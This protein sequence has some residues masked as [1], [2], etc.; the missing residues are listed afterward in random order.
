[1]VRELGRIYLQ[2]SIDCSETATLLTSLTTRN[3]ILKNIGN[4]EKYS[5]E[6]SFR[7]QEKIML[8]QSWLWV[9]LKCQK[10]NIYQS[11]EHI[12]RKDGCRW[13]KWEGINAQWLP[14]STWHKGI[15]EIFVLSNFLT[16]KFI[17]KDGK[18]EPDVVMKMF[19]DIIRTK[20]LS[21]FSSTVGVLGPACSNTVEAIAGVSKHYRYPNI[22]N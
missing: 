16:N 6:E 1:M 21:R 15:Y 10:N 3:A 2:V 18:C 20:A 4:L 19:I 17:S 11:I 14:V 22:Y 8:L 5:L 9:I 13:C 12:S 7:C